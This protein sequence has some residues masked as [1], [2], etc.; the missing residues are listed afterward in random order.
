[1]VEDRGAVASG[2][3]A[4]LDGARTVA[5]L[6]VVLCHATEHT[7]A[8]HGHAQMWD[9]Y[10]PE[11]TAVISV[12]IMVGRMGVP[13]FLFLTGS[14][15]MS[16]KI[17][18]ASDVLAF[19]KRNYLQLLIVCELWIAVSYV[20]FGLIKG[21]PFDPLELLCY[22]L[23]V[24]KLDVNI[25]WFIP[26]ILGVYLVMPFLAIVANKVSARAFAVPL[27]VAIGL[28]FVLPNVGQMMTVY[29]LERFKTILDLRFLGGEFGV[30]IV[31]G[32]CIYKGK[33]LRSATTLS[34][35]TMMLACLAGL[36]VYRLGI[37]NA[38]S[39]VNIWYDNTFLLGTT[40]FMFELMLRSR[41]LSWGNWLALNI[42]QCSMGIFLVHP[43]AMTLIE[44][45]AIGDLMLSTP[46]V[47][48]VFLL[49]GMTFWATFIVV[50]VLSRPR[51][52]GKYV[53]HVKRA[54][55]KRKVEE[56]PSDPPSDDGREEPETSPSNA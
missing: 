32:Y 54:K 45:F 39:K 18:T 17:E 49:W 51:P 24:K 16:K 26:M 55:R 5:M 43:I 50:W 4:V 33:M 35:V 1:M 8:I 41:V 42:S 23:F 36:V 47:P 53:F 25:M 10:S 30:Y 12:L 21:T 38:G 9:A 3:I 31:M 7:F 40:V 34:C 29:G 27:I 56:A 6:F 48:A 28:F 13:L 22:L 20:V 37:L 44:K 46:F 11:A 2:R 14:L 52:I 19:Y 15:V